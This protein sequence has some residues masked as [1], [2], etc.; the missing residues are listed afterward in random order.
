MSGLSSAHFDVVFKAAT[1]YISLNPLPASGHQF[2]LIFLHG[3][4][5][6]G[7]GFFDLFSEWDQH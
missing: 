6:S 2:T 1:K 4:G 5:D 7:E 3:L